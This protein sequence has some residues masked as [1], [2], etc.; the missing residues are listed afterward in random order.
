MKVR[1]IQSGNVYT[2]EDLGLEVVPELACASEMIPKLHS[3]ILE[4][5]KATTNTSIDDATLKMY[6]ESIPTTY[7]EPSSENNGGKT[8]YYD[9]PLPHPTKLAEIIRQHVDDVTA[10]LYE[11]VD[12]I[13][14]KFPST[15]NDLI[16][17]KDMYPFQHEIFKACYALQERASKDIKGG[18][19]LRELNKMKYYIERGIALAKKDKI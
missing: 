17:Y 15:L 11:T 8:N 7:P 16:E 13:Y 2:L 5:E 6:L 1:S 3:K 14:E 19:I 9:L 18:G 10:P 12:L 4:E